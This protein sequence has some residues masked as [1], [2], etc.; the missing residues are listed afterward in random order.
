M[1]STVSTLIDLACWGVR[2]SVA[3]E[4]PRANDERGRKTMSTNDSPG[5][6]ETGRIPEEPRYGRRAEP[7]ETSGQ[8]PGSP[9]PPPPPYGASGGYG[10]GQGTPSGPPSYGGYGQGQNPSYGGSQGSSATPPSYNAYGSGSSQPGSYNQPTG[11][12]QGSYGYG[13]PQGAPPKRTGPIAMIVI[14]ALLMILGPVIGFV[15]AASAGAGTF[16]DIANDGATISNGGTVSL[17]AGAERVIYI[18]TADPTASFSCEVIDPA[19]QPVSTRGASG[20]G[21]E[22]AGDS[23]LPGVEFTATEAGDYTVS[24][25]LPAGAQ[26]TLLI[27]PP[28]DLG[29]LVGAGLAVLIGFGAGFLGFILLIIGIIWLVRVNKRARTGQ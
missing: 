22:F 17:P 8:F 6:D 18:D 19:G 12:A 21:E 24:C 13:A 3:S 10:Q 23:L 28:L 20:E 25:D 1:A 16:T 5:P 9:P 29:G 26:D 2:A 11:Y 4:R 7:G 15:V 14:G 27:A